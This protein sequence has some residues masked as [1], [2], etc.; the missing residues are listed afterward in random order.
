M[1]SSINELFRL[2]SRFAS[3]FAKG[4]QS[5]KTVSRTH[6]GWLERIMMRDFIAVRYN[7][8]TKLRDVMVNHPTTLPV[9]TRA[10]GSSSS[11]PALVTHPLRILEK[12]VR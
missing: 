3:E 6:E 9:P 5:N 8:R 10:V 2:V 1:V 7:E 11:R 4:D 12:T